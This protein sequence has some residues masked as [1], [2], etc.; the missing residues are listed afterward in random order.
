MIE[1][2]KD[3]IKKIYPERPEE[4]K[5][6]D[7]GL[8]LVIG[9]SEFYSGSPALSALAAFR[10][11]V[12]MVRIIAPKRAADIDAS[13]MPDLVAYPL[14]G[15]CLRGAAHLATLLTQTEVAKDVSHGK[16]AVVIGGGIGRSK[17][18]QQVV[19][20]YLQ[21]VS[22]PVVVDADAI[23]ALSKNGG[24]I[25]QKPFLITPHTYEFFIL[26][27]REVYKIS[28]YEE[29]AKIVQ[30]EAKRLGTTIL[31]KGRTDIISDGENVAF[32]KTGGSFLAVGGTGD[33][34]AGIAGALLARGVSPFEAG[35]AAAY[36]NGLAGEI[37]GK[38]FG[39]SLMASD[40]INS[41]V[42]AIK[43]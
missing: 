42:E 26:T 19:L 16:T 33:T 36:L 1:V 3:I 11:G 29:K 5:K 9:G 24:I 38:E 12:D 13:F 4:S 39:D 10:A 2:T 32:N 28:S 27:G 41:I 22:V 21:K 35:Q 15:P 18:T 43:S 31:L 6:Y 25:S 34:L 14:D 37:A 40:L 17:E 23:H 20:N 30:E 8:L 7:L